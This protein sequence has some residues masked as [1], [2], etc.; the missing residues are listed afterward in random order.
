MGSTAIG[1]YPTPNGAI[2]PRIR[3]DIEALADAMDPV[4][5]PTFASTGARDT[6]YAAAIAAGKV[7][8]TCYITNRA[9]FSEYVHTDNSGGKGWRWRPQANDILTQTRPSAADSAGGNL[10]DIILLGPYV[11][12]PGNRRVQ[13]KT[14]SVVV[15]LTGGSAAARPQGQTTGNGFGTNQG[16]SQAATNFAGDTGLIQCDEIVVTS[17]TVSYS[18]RGRDGHATTPQSVRFTD[19]YMVVTDLGPA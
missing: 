14:R 19:S 6:A 5:T 15:Q 3:L 12:P 2:T 4:T 11:L 16:I 1:S 17:G 13:V 7:G 8:M 10:I 9:G 18:Y